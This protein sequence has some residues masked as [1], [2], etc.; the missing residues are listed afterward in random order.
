MQKKH[1]PKRNIKT[2]E[3]DPDVLEMVQKATESGI[4]FKEIMNRALRQ[5]G[6]RVIKAL[7]DERRKTLDSLSFNPPERQLARA[8]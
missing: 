5:H 7:A 6:K 2:F 1:M 4:T 3:P 8:A